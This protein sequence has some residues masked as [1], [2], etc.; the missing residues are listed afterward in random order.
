MTSALLVR[1]SPTN[2][3]EAG[4]DP[5]TGCFRIAFPSLL[6]ST[7]HVEHS[8]DLTSDSWSPVGTYGGT[9]AMINT[10][11]PVSAQRDFFRVA[12]NAV[13]LP[14]LFVDSVHGSDANDGLTEAA[15]LRSLNA[16]Q[17]AS[18]AGTVIGLARGS[19]WR[20]Q[21]SIPANNITFTTYGAGTMPIIDGADVAG[22]WTQPDAGNYPNVWSQSWT[23]S[24]VSSGSERL[25]YWENGV[26]P[27]RYA[28]SIADLQANG[29]WFC[30]NLNSQTSTV[31]IKVATNP[32]TDGIVREI[33]RRHYGINGHSATLR[34]TRT[35]QII[36]G[37]LEIKRCVGHY[38]A[39][40]L[41]AGAA[42]SLFLR[43]GNIHHMV[44][45]GEL[46]EDL[47]ATEFS[48]QIAPSVYVAY[49]GLGAGFNPV[50][51]RLLA[52]VPGGNARVSGSN[53]A[54]YSH[55]AVANQVP[56]VLIE[57]GISRGLNFANA[58]AQLFTIRG[59]YCEDPNEFFQASGSVFTQIENSLVR[60]TLASPLATGNS[61]LSRG[62]TTTTYRADHVAAHTM[63]GAALR[64]VPGGTRPIVRNVSISSGNEG[65]KGGEF[66]VRYSVFYCGYRPMNEITSSHLADFNVF[67]FIGQANPIL[68]W[69][70]TVYSSATTAFQS[71]V[72]AS[73]QDKSSVY[74]KPA[75]QT[76]G[77]LLAF[78]LGVANG[79]NSGPA[80]GDFRINPNARVYDRN[81]NA[82]IG[83]YGDGVTPITHAGPQQHWDFN[84]RMAV[85][86]P[87]SR[88]PVLPN[89]ISEMR[90]YVEDPTTW[91]FYP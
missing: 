40:S 2:I 68:H 38:N 50:F 43:D 58:S 65:M 66:D 82:R 54:F 75:D 86:G 27:V 37:P 13:A 25:G 87:P 83:T 15:A 20:E 89:S 17:A 76:N 78:W 73:G 44:S 63:K 5:L 74:L 1:A 72:A 61:V 79:A 90:S 14:T 91:N 18:R 35:G 10:S 46:M 53:S 24:A 81:N 34:A 11:H 23:T 31:Y 42:R 47:L 64:N 12:S 19:Y 3:S 39:L 22:T 67:Y 32:A 51:R 62:V 69:N 57:G 45:E 56:S 16:A 48:P 36:L 4:I 9:G 28:S 21:Y 55:A 77:N 60:D 59:C 26:R 6:G 88:Y 85:A 52:I 80:D 8:S 33:T 71:Y 70:G 84:L 30:S 29:G 49:K 41:G 7:Y